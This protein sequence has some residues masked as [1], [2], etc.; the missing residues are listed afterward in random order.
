MWKKRLVIKTFKK[1]D[2][3]DWRRVTLL[4]VTSKDIL[5]D[6][7]TVDHDSVKQEASKGPGCIKIKEKHS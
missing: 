1:G 3:H 5:Q 4:L 2:V 7:A 6:V